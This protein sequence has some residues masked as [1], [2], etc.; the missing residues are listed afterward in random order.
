MRIDEA[1]FEPLFTKG[2]G[3]P[4]ASAL[5]MVAILKEANGW[6]DSRL[7]EHC[8]FNILIKRA[9]GLYNMDDSIPAEST[10]YSFRKRIVDHEKQGKENLLESTFTAVTKGQAKEFQ[11]SGR[12][13]RMDSKLLGSNIA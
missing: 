12:S 11:V 6:S 4:N 1:L 8:R 3:S 13:I 9:L 2:T 5:T 7:F 10:Y